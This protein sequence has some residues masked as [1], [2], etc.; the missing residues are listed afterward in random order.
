MKEEPSRED[1]NKSLF[2]QLVMMLATSAS[3]QL[4]KLLNPVT[5]KVE[6][7]LEGAQATIDLLDMI[8]AKTRG[9][10]D[11]DEDRLLKDTLTSLKLTFVETRE[12]PAAGPSP[13]PEP[14][15]A[16]SAQGQPSADAP[17]PKFR[18]SYG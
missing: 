6:V 12:T 15:P 18:K 7:S 10:L 16:A 3:Q 11:R 8:A 14:A 13:A 4:G 2:I 9:N 17:P 1:V 5:R